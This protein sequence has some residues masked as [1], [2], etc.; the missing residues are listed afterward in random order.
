MER[1]TQVMIGGGVLVAVLGAYFA[2]TKYSAK[3]E[4]KNVILETKEINE[5]KEMKE[6]EKKE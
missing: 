3:S 1:K 5:M 6:K 2:W 4:P